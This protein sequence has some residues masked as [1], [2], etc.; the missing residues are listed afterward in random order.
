MQVC[1]SFSRNPKLFDRKEVDMVTG[2]ECW[3]CIVLKHGLRTPNE[4]FF[5]IEIPNFWAWAD[6]LGR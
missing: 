1:T 3:D 5:F 6:N 4:A 2:W